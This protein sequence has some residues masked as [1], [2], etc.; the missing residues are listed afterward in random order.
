LDFGDSPRRQTLAGTSLLHEVFRIAANHL[1]EGRQLLHLD[2]GSERDLLD[3]PHEQFRRHGGKLPVSRSHGV[4]LEAEA[5][6]ARREQQGCPVGSSLTQ[7]AH[8][9]LQGAV[10]LGVTRGIEGKILGG[11]AKDDQEVLQGFQEARAG[12]TGS[13]TL[14]LPLLIHADI[15]CQCS[16]HLEPKP[17]PEPVGG[18]YT[19]GWFEVKGI[20]GHGAMDFG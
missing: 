12:E 15:L 13:R 20:P 19:N 6:S 3:A 1:E 4:S 9:I 16:L 18:N 8:R 5:G 14:L 11:S 7:L 17:P 2:P 10:Q